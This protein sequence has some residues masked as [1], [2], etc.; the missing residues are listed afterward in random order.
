VVTESV[1]RAATRSRTDF[2]KDTGWRVLTSTV[3]GC[4]RYRVTGL[5]AEAAFFAI[6][7]VPPLVF[8]LAGSISFIVRKIDPGQIEAF[9]ESVLDLS[10]KVLTQESVDKIVAKTLNDVLD[11]QRFDVISI[12]FILSLW[13]GSRALHVFVDTITIMYGLGGQRGVV[14]TR[15]LSFSLYVVGLVVGVV[16]LPLVLAGPRLVDEFLPS[17]L[18]IV[19]ALYWPTVIVVSIAFLA[20]LFHLSVPVRTSWRHDLPGATLAFAIW[21]LGSYLLRLVLESSTTS[22]Y[23]PLAAPIAVLI[24]LYVTA[25]AVLV[26]AALNAAVD[27]LWPESST[28]RARLEQVRPQRSLDI[29]DV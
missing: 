27:R 29:D 15:M 2:A 14:R 25:L 23:G 12:G 26:G 5:A 8:G 20:S 18:D 11:G 7:S 3:G 19:N 9:R 4:F 21:A 17:R 10:S 24:W 16:V 6:L 28:A 22:I 1:G 13:S